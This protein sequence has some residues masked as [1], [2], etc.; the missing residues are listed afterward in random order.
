MILPSVLIAIAASSSPMV[1]A[2]AILALGLGHG[3]VLVAA[4]VF[5]GVLVR[6][7]AL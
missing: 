6:L 1:G 4:G 3:L 5:G 2:L 7:I